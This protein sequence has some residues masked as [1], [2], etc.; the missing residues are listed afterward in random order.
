MKILFVSVEVA[1]FAKVGGLADV[2]GSLPKALHSLGHDVRIAMPAYRMVLEDPRWNIVPQLA[3]LKVELGNH[4]LVEGHVS[5]TTI[6]EVP[7]ML[8]GGDDAFERAVNSQTVYGL[9][10]TQYLYLCKACLRACEDLNWIPD[11][12]HCND[13]HTGFLPVMLRLQSGDQ[14]ND[15][16]SVFTIHNFAYQG[17]FGHEVLEELGLPF[18]LFNMDQLETYGRVN[19]LKTGCVFSDVVNTVSPTYAAEIQTPEYGCRLEGLMRHLNEYGRLRGIL[20]GIDEDVF[21]PAEDKDLPERFDALHLQGKQTCKSELLKEL[22]FPATEGPLLGVV[23]RLSEQKGMDLLLEALPRIVA[24]G[25][26]VV[27][28]GLGS[29]QLADAFKSAQAQ[30]PDNVRFVEKF[31]AE[32]AQRVYAGVDM[33]LMPSAFE[34]CGLGQMI[35]LRYGSIPIVRKTGGLADTV[36]ENI[37]GFLFEHKDSSELAAACERAFKA[38]ANEKIWLKLMQNALSGDYGWSKSAS[39]YVHLYQQAINDR[40]GLSAAEAG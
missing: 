8:V 12:I 20:N 2:A 38:F 23:S 6:G 21:N 16:A 26:K 32:L 7:V 17:E 3:S 18:D 14:W 1:P 19:F 33:F 22:H 29:E 11:V 15:T 34:P 24:Q 10:F 27:V 30:F 36:F 28:Q 5:S 35:A 31:D 40:R 37:N 39:E 25:A 9:G 4:R 13:W